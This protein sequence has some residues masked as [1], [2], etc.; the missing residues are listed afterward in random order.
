MRIVTN[1]EMQKIDR[2]AQ[3]ELGIPS[4]VLMENAGRGC[5][6]VLAQYRRLRDQRVLVVCGPGNNGGDGLVI[7]RHAQNR[8]CAVQ[9]LLTVSARAL[10]GDALVNYQIAR[11][12]GF[13]LHT[14]AGPAELA[15]AIQTFHPTCIVDALFGTGFHGVP[16][17]RYA[18]MFEMI[19]ESDALVLAVDVPSGING[20]TGQFKRACV[21]ADVT[22]I[23]G[24]PKRGHWL[25]PGRELCGHLHLVDI[26]IPMDLLVDG[27]P[28]VPSYEFIGHLLPRRAPAGHKGTFGT[29]VTVAGAKGYS[30]A[31]VLSIRAA[32]K[33][34]AGYVRAAV[35]ASIAEI[36]EN[37]ALEAV[38][39][40]LPETASGTIARRSASILA[41]VLKHCSSVI[42]GPGLTTNEETALFLADILPLVSSPAVI[43][44]DALNIMARRPSLFR[45]LKVPFVITPHPGEFSRLTGHSPADVNN[46][47]IDLS[48]DH[49]RR[50]GGVVVLK[51]APTVVASP[52]GATYVNPTGNSGLATA[53]SG[54]V[55]AGMIGGLIAQ[56]ADVLSAAASAVFLHGLCADLALEKSNEYSLTAGD[57]LAYIPAAINRV[58][59][60]AAVSGVDFRKIRRHSS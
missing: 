42:L 16:A 21:V 11:R 40:V 53:G 5:V 60:F 52:S 24:L 10:A 29:V 23:M 46:R 41:P 15:R 1:E 28:Q 30:G 35:P 39:L 55:L 36:V 47:R 31:V 50:I 32:L 2:W 4:A 26:G 57:L 22:A 58:K 48:A 19:N 9:A 27:F 33:T 54:D 14:N 51:G 12:S 25:Y 56:G 37:R 43:D 49:A 45:R 6:E 17:L 8:G 44:A 7:A 59:R 13:D 3:R 18:R 38:K 20:D 34:G